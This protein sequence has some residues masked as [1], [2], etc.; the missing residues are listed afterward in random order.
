MK[1]AMDAAGRPCA[2]KHAWK[3]GWVMSSLGEVSKCRV[4]SGSFECRASAFHSSPG[5]TFNATCMAAAHNE[6]GSNVKGLRGCAALLG[7]S[8]DFPPFGAKSTQ[9][10]YAGAKST[11]KRLHGGQSQLDQLST[12]QPARA[13]HSSPRHASHASHAPPPRTAVPPPPLPP[14]SLTHAR[15]LSRSAAVSQASRL[16]QPCAA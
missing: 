9:G 7:L 12:T 3:T 5:L 6:S 4:V 15:S 13:T 14:R 10:G 1:L 2:W 16:H 11:Q 8:V